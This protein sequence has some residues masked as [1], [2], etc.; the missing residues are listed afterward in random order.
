[1]TKD[2]NKK[3]KIINFLEENMEENLGEFGF[4]DKCLGVSPKAQSRK[5]KINDLYCIKIN[6][7]CMW[8]SLLKE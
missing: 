2:Q 4:R 7:F 8:K 5:E 6:L 1:M 3:C